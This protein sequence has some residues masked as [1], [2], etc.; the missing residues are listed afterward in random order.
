MAELYVC[1]DRY[2]EVKGY[3][4]EGWYITYDYTVNPDL[5]FWVDEN[6]FVRSALRKPTGER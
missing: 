5:E 4:G 2:K 6:G 1:G 3:S